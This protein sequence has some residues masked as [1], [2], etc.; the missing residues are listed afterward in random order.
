MFVVVSVFEL[1]VNTLRM[2]NSTIRS[3]L[4]KIHIKKDLF[5]VSNHQ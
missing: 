2:M 4:S 1:I 5:E 3:E